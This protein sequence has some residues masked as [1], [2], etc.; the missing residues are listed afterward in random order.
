MKLQLHESTFEKIAVGNA[1]LREP[2]KPGKRS[3][4]LQLYKSGGWIQLVERFNSNIG[5]RKY[6]GP[7]KAMLP[8]GIKRLLK[9]QM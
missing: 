9:Q 1:Q 4:I 8:L 5:W 2:S 3:E 7:V 6:L